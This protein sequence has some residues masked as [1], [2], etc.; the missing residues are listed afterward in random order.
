MIF[1]PPITLKKPYHTLVNLLNFGQN[2]AHPNSGKIQPS[3][4]A[5]KI[6]ATS[7]A[8]ADEAIARGER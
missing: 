6:L 3:S 5:E 7:L 2:A 8:A 1:L 4:L